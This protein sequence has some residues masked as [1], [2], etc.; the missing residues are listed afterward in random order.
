[1]SRRGALE[2]IDLPNCWYQNSTRWEA[3]DHVP[4]EVYAPRSRAGAA[5]LTGNRRGCR[6][7]EV[8][9]IAELERSN[10]WEATAQ[11]HRLNGIPGDDPQLQVSI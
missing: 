8:S 7:P 3:S 5:S 10:A 6:Y 1:M 11:G 9:L 4:G 2:V